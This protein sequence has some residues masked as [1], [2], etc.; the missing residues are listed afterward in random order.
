MISYSMYQLATRHSSKVASAIAKP[1]ATML[2]GKIASGS[3]PFSTKRQKRDDELFQTP[4]SENAFDESDWLEA[5][6]KKEQHVHKGD[7]VEVGKKEQQVQKEEAKPQDNK[8]QERTKAL[9]GRGPAQHYKSPLFPSLFA[10]FDDLLARG[11]P[12][13]HPFLGARREPFFDTLMP[14]LRNFPAKN[15]PRSTLLRSSP[16]Y[17]IKENDG[18]YEIAI[19]IPDGIQASDMKVELEH[20]GTVLHL[21]GGRKVEE[22]G[23]IF[24]TQFNKRFTIGPNVKTDN[25]TANFSDG[26]LVLTAPK[27]EKVLE[28]PK[29]PT[30]AVT[31]IP[32]GDLP[33]DQEMIQKDYS[34]EVDESDPVETGKPGRK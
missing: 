11:D 13:S 30:I 33:T 16:G 25:I 7:S 2:S 23:K 19:D 18:T 9:G 24:T 10:G 4:F 27:I 3:V 17:E 29:H 15:D 5:G 14:V 1:A 34:V 21:S 20:D 32:H 8:Q 12:F 31:D 28:T 22:K 26:V 6:K